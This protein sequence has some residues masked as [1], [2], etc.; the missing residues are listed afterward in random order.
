MIFFKEN[1]DAQKDIATSTSKSKKKRVI[2]C[3][4]HIVWFSEYITFL[5]KISMSVLL[6]QIS[7]S[8]LFL[9]ISMSVLLYINGCFVIS[10]I[11]ECFLLQISMNVLLLQ[12]SMSVL[13]EKVAAPIS[14]WTHSAALNVNVMLGTHWTTQANNVN[15]S[16]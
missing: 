16:L 14:V 10:D 15:V 5:L 1:V 6:L 12:I 9:H 8:V 2:R 7:M 11:N 4:I 13:W 3:I